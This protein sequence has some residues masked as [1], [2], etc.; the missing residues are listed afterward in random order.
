MTDNFTVIKKFNL[1]PIIPMGDNKKPMVKWS[2]PNNHIYSADEAIKKYPNTGAWA[3]VTGEKSDIMVIDIDNK[4]GQ[5]GMDHFV[6]ILKKFSEKDNKIIRSTLMVKTPNNGVHLYFKYKKG[7]RTVSNIIPGVDIRTD[8]GIIITPNST[9]KRKDGKYAIYQTNKNTSDIKEIPGALFDYLVSKLD[10]K[11]DKKEATKGD[12]SPKDTDKSN[13]K[14][15]NTKSFYREVKEGERD[16][17]LFKYICR[18]VKFFKEDELYQIAKMYNNEHIK[19]PLTDKEVREKV[20]SA[21]KYKTKD[22][23]DDNGRIVIGALVKAYANSNYLFKKGNRLYK[24]NKTTGIYDVLN[25][26]MIQKIYYQIADVDGAVEDISHKKADNFNKTLFQYIDGYEETHDEKRYIACK[27]GI[28]DSI[29]NKLLPFDPKYKLDC[30]FNGTYDGNYDKWLEAYNK[31]KFKQFLLDILVDRDVI[32]SLQEMWGNMLCPHAEKIQQIFIYYG[33]GSNG[34]SSLFDIQEA[35]FSNLEQNLCGISLSAFS[36]D[37]FIL[38]MAQGKR[39]NIVRDDKLAKD[40]GGSFKSIIN[41]EIVTTQEK[42]KSHKYQKFNLAWFYGV[43]SL[44][45]TEDKTNG[46]YRR[47]CIIPFPVIFGTKEEV[48]SGKANKVKIPGIVDEIIEKE[49]DIV[50]MWAYW[51]LQRLIKQNWIITPNKASMNIAEEY[52]M[53]TNSVYE[54]YTE[55][56]VKVKGSKIKSKNLYENYLSWCEKEYRDPVKVVTFGKQLKDLGHRKYTSCGIKCFENLDYKSK[57]NDGGK[58]IILE[59]MQDNQ[60]NPFK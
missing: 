24:Y 53:E 15:N 37:K 23:I 49:M 14:S 55:K 3:T 57:Q 44:P 2:D 54:Y 59:E 58:V 7:L 8:G 35:L 32:W 34:K 18:M 40:V 50:F 45:N 47:N 20:N 42:N 17:V 48:K 25:D 33:S 11:T 16:E 38:S 12:T 27:N 21:L 22:Y 60:E 51:G 13:K 5:N 52:K 43:N 41:G 56:L 26:D 10:K 29:D 9:V 19:P 28:I 46:Y 1:F 36:N 4:N 6:G 39:V 30:K 31:S